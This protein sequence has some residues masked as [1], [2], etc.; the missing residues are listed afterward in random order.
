MVHL[1]KFCRV[2]VVW[3]SVATILGVPL[4]QLDCLSEGSCKQKS[5]TWISYSFASQI[6]I[7]ISLFLPPVSKPPHPALSLKKLLMIALAD[8]PGR[9]VTPINLSL[10]LHNHSGSIRYVHWFSLHQFF[11]APSPYFC[12]WICLSYF[13]FSYMFPFHLFS[14]RW[15][16]H[17]LIWPC[18]PFEA[19]LSSNPLDQTCRFGEKNWRIRHPWK[20]YVEIILRKRYGRS[21]GRRM[22]RS[23]YF[24]NRPIN[25]PLQQWRDPCDTDHSKPINAT[26]PQRFCQGE[27]ESCFP[28]RVRPCK[29]I[30]INDKYSICL[31]NVSEFERLVSCSKPS[32]G[33]LTV[34]HT[35]DIPVFSRFPHT[36]VTTHVPAIARA[37][38][39]LMNAL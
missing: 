37:V 14:V 33:C 28:V 15:S 10:K 23:N 30:C 34:S 11:S 29:W 6:N 9:Q 2:W 32:F 17:T 35:S 24:S 1:G 26:K 20:N 22:S 5:L 4:M 12:S 27:S 39:F 13:I 19:F 38:A 31:S 8:A 25:K 36:A 7:M 3:A 18:G 16:L 21:V